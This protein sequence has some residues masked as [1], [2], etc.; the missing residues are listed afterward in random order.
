M[1]RFVA[2]PAVAFT[3]RSADWLPDDAR[4]VVRIG[5]H[6]KLH[7]LGYKAQPVVASV[8]W[9][10]SSG[11]MNP[12][13]LRKQQIK[14]AR[15]AARAASDAAA[16]ADIKAQYETAISRFNE[17]FDWEERKLMMSAAYW[18]ARYQHCQTTGTSYGSINKGIRA[19]ARAARV[20]VS[21]SEDWQAD[22]RAN[23]GFF[24]ESLWGVNTKTACMIGD[25]DTRAWMRSWVIDNMGHR[26]GVRNKM[27]PDFNKAL[28]EHLELPWVP[29]PSKDQPNPISLSQSLAA[30]HRFVGAQYRNVKLG[31]IHTDNHG[32]DHVVN[33]QRPAFL[34]IYRQVYARGPNFVKV[35]T[36]W[37]LD[38][39]LDKDEV[40]DLMAS[41]M[42][43]KPECTGPRGI[44]MGGA[45][46]P[47]YSNRLLPFTRADRPRKTWHL[48]CHDECC[49]HSLGEQGTMWVIPGVEMGDFPSKS[50]ADINH[51]AEADGE[52]APGCLT[53]DGEIGQTERKDLI[54]YHND[55]ANP[56]ENPLIPHHS[57]ISMHAGGGNEGSW[58]GDDAC[59]HAE[60]LM[61]QF[62]VEFN[63]EESVPDMT[64]ARASD[65]RDLTQEQIDEHE[66]GLAMQVDRSQGH[67]KRDPTSLNV[68]NDPGIN[69]GPGRK[70]P[71]F[72]HS[73]APL[74]DGFT[75]WTQ[76]RA[77]L[78]EPG[79][80]TCQAAVNEHGNR[81]DFQSQGKKGSKIIL[82]E[83]GLFV[84]GMLAPQQ[85]KLL[86]S[87]PDWGQ[88]KSAM[89]EMFERRGHL[90]I[91]G[92]ACHPEMASKEHG[93]SR[94]KAKVKPLVTGA[95]LQLR[96]LVLAAIKQITQKAR[97][98]DN[99]R[100]REVMKAFRS[101]AALG[102]EATSDSLNLCVITFIKNRGVTP[103]NCK[104]TFLC[105]CLLR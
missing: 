87:Q 56:N 11:A 73:F 5:K 31:S 54:K 40:P 69:A 63:L 6:P 39:W 81:P 38:E 50:D 64:L 20:H 60:V 3:K 57:S 8:P 37:F 92:V 51:L 101:L 98:E 66:H 26:K 53:L 34:D 61:D 55:R 4:R 95:Y 33:F 30:L 77:A 99:R 17:T 90:L 89:Q 84:A 19:G 36:G 102:E 65:V 13:R 70:Q 45:V 83:R 78:C 103:H 29:N 32:A 72:R 49:V 41:G 21:T 62:D 28:H 88:L 67:L 52:F 1:D 100:C 96:I 68:N 35:R 85:K 74:P 27:N 25:V 42:L 47:D 82:A 12:D 86:Q 24:S 59:A 10:G 46:K 97:L 94:L 79:C 9:T 91:I 48:M 43:D 23:K 22:W 58:M 18:S 44:N 14:Q 93:W 76:C 71:H 16:L 105:N 15:D 75:H 2:L 80:A 104:P 7:F